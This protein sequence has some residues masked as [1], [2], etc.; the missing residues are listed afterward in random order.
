MDACLSNMIRILFG[1]GVG[2]YLAQNY[3][4]P[5][6]KLFVNTMLLYLKEFE[7]NLQEKGKKS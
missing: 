6:A 5:D 4:V 1:M 7:T 2:I 3:N